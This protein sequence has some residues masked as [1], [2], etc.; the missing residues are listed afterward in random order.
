MKTDLTFTILYACNLQWKIGKKINTIIFVLFWKMVQSSIEFILYESSMRHQWN[1][2]STITHCHNLML[3]LAD[4]SKASGI[5]HRCTLHWCKTETRQR[6][7]NGNGKEDFLTVLIEM[8][9]HQLWYDREQDTD[10]SIP[11]LILKP[12]PL[13]SQLKTGCTAWN[14]TYLASHHAHSEDTK[15]NYGKT[16]FF[17]EPDFLKT[18]TRVPH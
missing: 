7:G 3:P 10:H 1:F 15:R 4:H 18:H 14:H 11:T 6:C 13:R 8:M 5:L 17:T 12:L 2:V 9:T 16:A